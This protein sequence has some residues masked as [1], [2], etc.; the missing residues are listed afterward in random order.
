MP[1]SIIGD[2]Q[3]C[4]LTYFVIA[5]VRF[6]TMPRWKPLRFYDV[7]EDI[8]FVLFF[9]LRMMLKY[10]TQLCSVAS[11]ASWPLVMP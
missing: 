11:I 2:T 7:I 10:S 6:L 1:E 9:C 5:L 4:F 3:N 8:F